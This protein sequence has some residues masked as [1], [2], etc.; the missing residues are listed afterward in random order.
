MK[1]AGGEKID[2]GE[3]LPGVRSADY[4]IG[5]F[6]LELKIVEEE[7]LDKPERQAKIAELFAEEFP[8]F[9]TVVI[10]PYLLSSDATQ[11][12]LFRMLEG[13]IKGLVKTA[14]KQLKSS[15]KKYDTDKKVLLILN[16]GYMSLH[17]EDFEKLVL[18]CV[19]NDTSNIDLVIVGGMYYEYDGFDSY[20]LAYFRPHP[21]DVTKSIDTSSLER[22]WNHFLTEVMNRFALEQNTEKDARTPNADLSFSYDGKVF[23]RP[24]PQFG[25][26]SSFFPNGRPRSN[27][28][29]KTPLPPV[30]IVMPKVSEEEWKNLRVDLEGADGLPETFNEWR[31]EQLELSGPEDPLQPKISFRTPFN[32]FISESKSSAGLKSWNDFKVFAST[33][34]SKMARKIAEDAIELPS[35]ISVGGRFIFVETVEIGSDKAFDFSSIQLISDMPGLERKETL[36]EHHRIFFEHA[37]VLGAAYAVRHGC[38]NVYWAKNTEFGWT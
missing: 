38:S 3:E 12:R 15:A 33:E 1:K 14:S 23:V 36:I 21:I 4:K 20:V 17:H 24:R 29:G 35:E 13:P 31:E 8:D 30:A 5:D 25:K 37:L 26:K 18:K 7:G 34:F 27:S 10:N 11:G 2:L 22:E 19:R 9:P 6:V 32:E 28:S 16:N